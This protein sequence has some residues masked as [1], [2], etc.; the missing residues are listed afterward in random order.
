MERKTLIF[1]IQHYSL[2]DG[3]GIRT[4]LFLK[5]CPMRCK[6]CANPESQS[7]QKEV[8]WQEATEH[9]EESYTE[10]GKEAEISYLLDEVEKD[11]IF[12]NRGKGG[13]TV[14][15]GEPLAHGRFLID[16][17]K[18]AKKR[19]IHTAME[20]C[21]YGEYEVLEEAARYLDVILYD[22]KSLNEQKHIAFTGK[23]NKKILKNFVRLCEE[24]KKLQKIV[25]TPVIPT[26]NDTK[27]ELEEI[28]NFIRDKENVSYELLPYHCFG[29]EK[30][31]KLRRKYEMGKVE[32]SDEIKNYIEE[33]NK[34]N[35]K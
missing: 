20:T 28:E 17:L 31:K 23:S 34:K 3:P 30:Y 21:G 32:L 11:A 25:R 4:I 12:Y 9:V 10:I 22:I 8:F 14:S 2:H 24:N 26:F 6:W 1:N 29:V 5:G 33:R 18:E 13:L 15:G 35:K 19:R 16:L 27:E 7:F